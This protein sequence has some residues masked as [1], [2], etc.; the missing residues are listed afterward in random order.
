MAALPAALLTTG[1]CRLLEP[2]VVNGDGLGYLKAA[3][4]H[5]LYPGHVGY[6]PLLRLLFSAA[7]VGPRAVDGLVA[8]RWLSHVAAGA[9]V[10]LLAATANWLAGRRAAWVAGAGLGACFAVLASGSD[11]ECYAP[12]LAAVSAALYCVVRRRAGGRALLAVGAGLAAAVAALLH[13]ENLL[14]FGAVALALRRRDRWL[15][16]ACGGAVVA[17]AYL[18]AWPARGGLGWLV[19][20][21]HGFTYPFRAAAPLVAVYGAAKALVYSPY[22]YEAPMVSVLLSTALGALALAALLM[23]G[24]DA[25]AAA[26]GRAATAA[27]LAPYALVGLLYF[28]SDAERWIFLLPLLWLA[29]ARARR[30]G[31][32]L[33]LAAAIA[34]ANLALWW[35]RARDQTWRLE[36]AAAGRHCRA[37]DLVVSPG[38]GWDE[39]IGFYDGAEVETFPLVYFAGAL[40]TNQALRQALESAAARARARGSR[41]L[42]AR[43]GGGDRLGWKDLAPLGVTPESVAALLPPG[44]RLPLGDGIEL[45]KE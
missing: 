13:L 32:V 45:L 9:A 7:R 28:P 29:V 21:G 30:T 1:L 17:A 26:L 34:L 15:A 16:L 11:V 10:L 35:P 25:W 5:V 42:L 36:A 18:G 39:Y 31:L 19:G 20:A 4:S 38:H 8:A 40:G 2:A 27:W 37:G 44:H 33:G 24:R 43:M 12:A 22:P 14:L 3:R 41:V 23:L 6:V